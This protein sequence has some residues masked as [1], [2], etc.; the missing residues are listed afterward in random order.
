VLINGTAIFRAAGYYTVPFNATYRIKV[1]I[2]VGI[3]DAPTLTLYEDGVPV[4]N[5][6]LLSV[7]APFRT[8]EIEY[9]AIEGVNLRVWTTA[10]YYYY[11]SI[12]IIEID[13]AQIGYGSAVTPRLHLPNM[14]QIDFIKMICNMFGLIPD[15]IPRDRRIR[16]WN[17]SDLYDN[18]PVARDWSAYLSERD[19]EVEFKFGDYAQNNYLKYRE[20]EDV[21]PN[22][23]QG[24]MQ[25]DDETL[26]IKKDI[27]EVPVSTCDE[28]TIATTLP[29]TVSRIAFNIFDDPTLADF[30]Q[31]KQEDGIDARIVYCKEATGRLFTLWDDDAMSVNDVDID[32]PKIISSHE[33]AFSSLVVNYAYLS[34]MLTKTNLRRAKFNLPVYEVACLKHYIPIYLSQYKAYFYVNKI[35]NYVPGKLCTIDL[36]KL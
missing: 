6:D 32:D 25:V 36:I 30:Q 34:R 29:M 8:Y 4:G 13:D 11:Y 35:N 16:F 10:A 5:F 12:A 15:F 7:S 14:T 1:V 2:S 21:I 27:L 24:I 9:T 31:Y 33:V 17:Y 3:A 18:I 22:N 28:V 20:S 19:D 26:P 23:G